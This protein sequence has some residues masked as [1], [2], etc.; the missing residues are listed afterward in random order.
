[1][2]MLLILN[3]FLHTNIKIKYTAKHF[4]K[5]CIFGKHNNP[6]ILISFNGLNNKKIHFRSW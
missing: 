1:M 4:S 3:N 2:I 6:C 5:I